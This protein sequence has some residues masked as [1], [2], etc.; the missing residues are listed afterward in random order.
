M[1]ETS[2]QMIAVCGL[3]CDSCDIRRVPTDPEAA[4]RVVAWFKEM[5]W[6]EEDEGVS[7]VIQ[8]S[9]YCT[10]CRGDRSV[11]WSPD[12]WI[13]KCC[14]DDKGLAFCYECDAFPC[15]RLNDWA[16]ESVRYTR[17]LNRLKHMRGG[18]T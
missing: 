14:V 2:K 7:E 11:H 13:L 5:G 12:C 8:R 9:M 1:K 10:G 4:Q 6:L 3:D 18:I 17:A 15:E 16:G